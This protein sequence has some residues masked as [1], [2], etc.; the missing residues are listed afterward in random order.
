MTRRFG[1]PLAASVLLHGGMAALL[2][3]LIGRLPPPLPIAVQKAGIEITLA[4]PPPAPAPA[5]P[6]A[7]TPP[8]AETPPAPPEPPPVAEAA[9]QP[10]PPAAK[11]EPPPPVP[12]AKPEPPPPPPHPIRR[13]AKPPPR[14]APHRTARERRFEPPAIPFTPAPPVPRVAALPPAP[15]PPPR[16]AGPLV[17]PGYTAAL[18]AWLDRHKQYPE[19]ARARGEQGQAVVRFQVERTG[20]LLG[21]AIVRSTGYPDLDAALERM[22]RGATLPPFPADMRASDIDVSVTVRFAL[23]R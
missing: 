13:A 17:T 23:A 11:P 22:M 7:E 19:A 14:P 8:V 10:P 15:T 5:P 18:S 2:V 20:R 6:A 3:L 4:P 16:P 1:L 12:A 21:F 9:P